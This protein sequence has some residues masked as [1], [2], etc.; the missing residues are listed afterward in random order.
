MGQ[1][2]HPSQTTVV[3]R[4]SSL[5][6]ECA[7]LHVGKCVSVYSLDCY[8][9]RKPGSDGKTSLLLTTVTNAKVD[10]GGQSTVWSL[11]PVKVRDQRT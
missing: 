6:S 2:R 5:T 3:S 11:Q 9:Q 4:H 1:P 7:T 10:Q 8:R